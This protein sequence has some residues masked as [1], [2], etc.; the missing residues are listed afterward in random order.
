MTSSRA[1][2]QKWVGLLEQK[3]EMGERQNLQGEVVIFK[4][5]NF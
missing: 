5:E 1:I 2:A 4:G 3:K